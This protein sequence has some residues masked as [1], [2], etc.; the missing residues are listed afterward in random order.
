MELRVVARGSN[1]Q[2]YVDD[3]LITTVQDSSFRSGRVGVGV[4]NDADQDGAEMFF[5]NLRVFGIR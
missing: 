2:F 3:G 4:L 5:D 1:F